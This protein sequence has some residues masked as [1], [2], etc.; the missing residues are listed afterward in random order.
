MALI[1]ATTPFSGHVFSLAANQPPVG[2]AV[3]VIGYPEGGPVSFSHGTVSGLGRT[4]NIEGQRRTGLV[5][6]DVP[7]NPGNSGGPLLLV[8]GAVVGLA[9]AVNSSAQG[10]GY[11]VLVR[12]AAPLFSA[13]Q[14]DPSPQSPPTCSDPLGPSGFGQIGNGTAA[15]A[16]VVPPLT[17]YFDAIDAGDYAT[18]YAQL[19]PAEQATISEAQFAADDATSY[20]YN[21]VV[22]AAVATA[23]GAELVDVSFTGLQ[24]PDVSPSGDQCDNW[25][26]EYTMV[27]LGGAW[28]IQD[29]NGQNGISYVRC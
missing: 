13:W 12:S 22:G 3:G 23:N 17:T 28:L 10:I 27:S 19:A 21:V 26:L 24:S 7:L 4:V 18:A 29:A 16:G 15:P 2:T 5:Q 14:G 1:Q 20:D 11:A 25:T 6:T 8:D 9:D